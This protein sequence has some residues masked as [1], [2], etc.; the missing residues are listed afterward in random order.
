M[1]ETAEQKKRK[2]RASTMDRGKEVKNCGGGL[3]RSNSCGAVDKV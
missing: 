1:V 2:E 3:D